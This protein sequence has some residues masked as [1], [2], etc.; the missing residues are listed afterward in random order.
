MFN[1]SGGNWIQIRQQKKRVTP[2]PTPLIPAQILREVLQKLPQIHITPEKPHFHGYHIREDSKDQNKIF[3]SS[4][5]LN[6]VESHLQQKSDHFWKLLFL[7]LATLAHEYGH[8]LRT[9]VFG[10]DNTPLKLSYP[11]AL[12]GAKDGEGESG[13]VAEIALFN[14]FV[15]AEREANGSYTGLRIVDKMNI[16]HRIPTRLVQQYWDREQFQPF[17]LDDPVYPKDP[18]YTMTESLRSS[19]T[20]AKRTGR[21]SLIQEVVPLCPCAPFLVL[22]EMR[23]EVLLG[24]RPQKPDIKLFEV[25]YG[26][27]EEEQVRLIW[28]QVLSLV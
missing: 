24:K 26:W 28:A 22:A 20:D 13:F 19:E 21:E 17:I 5:L 16:S 11:H 2:L 23:V 3:I 25:K 1:I 12:A 4:H 8:W 7:L 15:Q 18:L 14:G 9:A 10:T 6:A 27:M